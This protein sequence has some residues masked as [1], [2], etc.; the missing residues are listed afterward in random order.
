MLQC[1]IIHDLLSLFHSGPTDIHLSGNTTDKLSVSGLHIDAA[2]GSPTAYQFCLIVTDYHGLNDSDIATV[3]YSKGLRV[4]VCVCVCVCVYVCV[5]VFVCECMCV[6]VCLC[7]SVCV[8]VCLCVLCV[9]VCVN[10]SHTRH[11]LV[12]RLHSQAGEWSLGTRL[13]RH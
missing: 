8:C 9:H 10:V 3:L 11:S 13:T 5:C 2:V 12:P 4:C 1:S 7:V 6:C